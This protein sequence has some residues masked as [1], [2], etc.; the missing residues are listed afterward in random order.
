[1]PSRAQKTKSSAP[2]TGAASTSLGTSAPSG[3]HRVTCIKTSADIFSFGT[4]L[5]TGF[6][7]LNLSGA[8][9]LCKTSLVMSCTSGKLRSLSTSRGAF[10]APMKM[11]C[12][13]EKP[14][15]PLRLDLL[16]VRAPSHLCQVFLAAEN[17]FRFCPCSGKTTSQVF[18]DLKQLSSVDLATC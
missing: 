9:L 8:C 6:C 4:T 11:S 15:Q 1:M 14:A 13:S 10:A 12:L 5:G 16:R 7:N 2:S 17:S 3:I 18:R